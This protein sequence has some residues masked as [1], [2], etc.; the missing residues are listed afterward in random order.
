MTK[1]EKREL[2]IQ[3]WQMLWPIVLLTLVQKLGSAFEGILVSVNHAEELTV[4]SICSPYITLIN[5]V[6]Y[7]LGIAINSMTGQFVGKGLWEECHRRAIRFVMLLLLAAGCIMSVITVFLLIQAFRPAPELRSTGFIYMLP[8]L[9]GS[10]VML[11]FN[12]LISG[13]RGF[14]DSKTGMY[15]TCMIIPLQLFL[16]WV[17]YTSFGLPVLGYGMILARTA[18]C[19]YGVRHYRRRYVPENTADKPLPEGFS[20]DFLRLAVP[21][22]LSKMIGPMAHTL[23]NGML[24]S[25]GAAY[26]GASGLGGRLEGFFYMPAMAMGS[27]TITLT[28]Q[29]KKDGNMSVLIRR[30]CIWSVTPTLFMILLAGI[31]SGPA[32]NMLTADA[33]LRAAGVKYWHI[34]LPAYPLIALEMTTTGI[35]QAY[36]CGLPALVVTLIRLWGVQLPAAWLSVRYEWGAAGVWMGFLLSNVVSLVISVVWAWKKL[37]PDKFDKKER[38]EIS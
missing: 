7:G 23:L 17:L 4:I 38:G 21:V 27:V 33:A 35:L 2:D 9:L 20:R 12:A 5:T 19:V 32:W 3:I 24:L 26:V 28:A 13:M 18:G 6:S 14:K 34:C 1:K 37:K 36:G 8:Y 10:P 16:S 30:L 31:F 25:I 11:L 15:M 29:Q 22:S